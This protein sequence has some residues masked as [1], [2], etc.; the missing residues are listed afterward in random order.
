VLTGP[1]ATHVRGVAGDGRITAGHLAV[2]RNASQHGRAADVSWP[3]LRD[4]AGFAADRYERHPG[5][6]RQE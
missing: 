6:I 5:Y 1:D 2:L 4:F 3:L